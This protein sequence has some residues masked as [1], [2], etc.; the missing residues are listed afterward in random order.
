MSKAA[1]VALPVPVARATA[2]SQSPDSSSW[3]IREWTPAYSDHGSGLRLE[4]AGFWASSLSSSLTTVFEACQAVSN[5]PPEPRAM[6][7]RLS[8]DAKSNESHTLIARGSGGAFEKARQTTAAAVRSELTELGQN[9][10]SSG[11]SPLPWSEYAGVHQQIRA[12]DDGGNW[13]G[14]VTLATGTG[15]ATFAAFD[16]SSDAQLG[17]LSGQTSQQLDD[18]GG[19]LPISGA[20]GLLAGLVAAA[21]AWWGV[22]QRLE[23]YR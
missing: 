15:N 4:D 7:V 11:L 20:L 3:R 5:A 13:D 14:A 16:E 19:W 18:A 2:P 23:E 10:A 17:T 1:N 9:P 6:R 12:L 21:S 22:S 8:F